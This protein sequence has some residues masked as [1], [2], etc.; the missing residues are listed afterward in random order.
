MAR[1][2]RG[3]TKRNGFALRDS[4]FKKLV[5]SRRHFVE[6]LLDN[7]D[8]L[9]DP[10]TMPT[11]ARDRKAMITEIKDLLQLIRQFGDLAEVEKDGREDTGSI[12]T[13]DEKTSKMLNDA[14]S[15]LKL[16]PK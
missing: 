3:R 9:M 13:F 14:Q 10:E 8:K 15:L 16:V 7:V 5:K 12:E 6:M 1:G 11:N 2:N 4:N